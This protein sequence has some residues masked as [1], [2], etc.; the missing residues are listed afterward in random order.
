MPSCIR[1]DSTHLNVDIDGAVAKYMRA[2]EFDP[3]YANAHFNEALA[4]QGLNRAGDAADAFQRYLDLRPDAGNAEQV[5]ALIEQ[6]RAS[7]TND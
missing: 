3:G 1:N 4:L 6:L 5:R 7:A 2:T